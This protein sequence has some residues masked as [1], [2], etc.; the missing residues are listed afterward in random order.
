MLRNRYAKHN[1]PLPLTNII[2]S[3]DLRSE[4]KNQC[5]IHSREKIITMMVIMWTK[6][7]KH[8]SMKENQI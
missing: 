4:G 7:P 8:K 1:R 2:Y 5:S 6:G 3:I